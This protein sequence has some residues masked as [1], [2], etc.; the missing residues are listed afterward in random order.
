MS[1]YITL[2]VKQL[3]F[4]LSFIPMNAFQ[5]TYNLVIAH[6]SYVYITIQHNSDAKR[7]K[8]FIYLL[9]GP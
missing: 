9:N 8:F 2:I 1:S 6:L 3:P 4:K 7:H 5:V